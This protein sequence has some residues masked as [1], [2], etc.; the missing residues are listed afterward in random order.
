MSE[1]WIHKFTFGSVSIQC[2]EDEDNKVFYASVK[3]SGC[4]KSFFYPLDMISFDFMNCTWSLYL[5]FDFLVALKS[6]NANLL[7]RTIMN[8]FRNLN[9]VWP[10]EMIVLMWGGRHHLCTM[11]WYLVW[12]LM[13][14]SLNCIYQTLSLCCKYFSDV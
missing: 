2:N 12:N 13:L 3:I 6:T 7:K 14:P 9:K 8:L 1:P 11:I 5:L 10:F 4:T